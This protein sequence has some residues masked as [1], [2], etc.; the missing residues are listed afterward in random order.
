MNVHGIND[1]SHT[2]MHTAETLVHECSSCK[3]EIAIEKLKMYKTPG[4]D[5]IQG[6][7]IQASGNT[8]CSEIYKLINSVWNKNCHSSGRNLLLYLIYK[9]VDKTNCSNYRGTLLLPTTY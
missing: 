7:M 6:Q 2:E 3:H 1:A 5:Q 4:T 8:L 9:K